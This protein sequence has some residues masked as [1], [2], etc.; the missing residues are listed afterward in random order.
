MELTCAEDKKE[1]VNQI[2]VYSGERFEAVNEAAAGSV[3]AV[4]GLLGTMAGQGLGM[5]KNLESPFLTPVLSY[6]LLL[7]EGTRSNG[8]DAKAE[9]AGGR[10]SGRCLLPGKRSLRRSMCMSWA[11]FR[12][13]S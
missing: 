7:P 6:C 5:E 3:C 10:G 1:K 2:R 12:W 4:T 9:G 13:R 11:R 8:G